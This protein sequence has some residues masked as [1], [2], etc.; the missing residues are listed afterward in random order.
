MQQIAGVAQ[1]GGEE[2]GLMMQ[3]STPPSA[4]ATC[5]R[6]LRDVGAGL[7]LVMGA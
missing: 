2:W 3:L 1:Q 4:P 6:V 7:A 5:M